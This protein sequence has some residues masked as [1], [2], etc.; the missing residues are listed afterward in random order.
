MS[1]PLLPNGVNKN[2]F[3]GNSRVSPAP[4]NKGPIDSSTPLGSIGVGIASGFIPGPSPIPFDSKIGSRVDS[5]T[6]SPKL[7]LIG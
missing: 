2:L 3:L 7:D 6:A 5:Q 1:Y 4:E